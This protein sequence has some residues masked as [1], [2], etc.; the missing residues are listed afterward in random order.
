MLAWLAWLGVPGAAGAQPNITPRA[1]K[2]LAETLFDH[3]LE[4]MR[5]GDFEHACVQLEQS[6][7]IERGIGTM[8]Y[9]AECYEKLGKTASAWA[10]FREAASAARAE[11]QFDRAR[12]GASRAER[13]EP[14]L[15]KLTIQASETP[16]GLVVKRNGQVLPSAAFGV[17]LPSDPGIQRIE[18]EAPGR[19]PWSVTANLPANGAGVTVTVP[20]LAAA[21]DV[22]DVTRAPVLA[23][24]APLPAATASEPLRTPPPVVS[25]AHASWQRPLGFVLGGAGV[26]ALGVGAAFWARAIS[27][28]SDLEAACPDPR[29]VCAS[30]NRHLQDRAQSSADVST[31]LF[32]GGAVLLGAGLV[33]LLTAPSERALALGVRG[34]MA[35]AQLQL[36]GSL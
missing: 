13:L 8:L 2:A 11:N 25:T 34:D 20:A 36:T 27:Q 19:S 33:V 18:A 12:V 28:N 1:D 5:Q 10:M 3:G 29:T 7:N 22:T 24:Q 32:I 14:A 31:G 16:P 6:E 9:L 17:A 35:G 21:A 30:T 4:L 23:V 26:V 15:S